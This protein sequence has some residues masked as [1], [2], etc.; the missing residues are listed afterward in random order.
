MGG[1]QSHSFSNKELN[2]VSV[3]QRRRSAVR[4][5]Q[6]SLSS[7]AERIRRHATVHFGYST[8][9]LA[10]RGLGETPAELWELREV[11]KLNLSMNCLCSLPPTLSALDNLVILNLWGNN[12]SSLPPEIGLLK[13]L[14]VLFACRNRLSEVPEELGSCTCLE[15]LSLANNQITGLPGSLAAMHNLTK[16]N[17]SHNRISHIP[18]LCLQ[19]EGPGV[20]PPCL[21]PSG[22]HCGPD[23]G[24]S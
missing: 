1:K 13:K 4:D 5:D 10:M 18:T 6:P 9:S 21:Q 22:D 11:Q 15:V 17:L 7:A 12:L 20:P 19:H 24:L 8:L 23:P 3:S 14:R 16:L 2:E